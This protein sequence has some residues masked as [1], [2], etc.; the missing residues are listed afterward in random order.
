MRNAL[1]DKYSNSPEEKDRRE[2][3]HRVLIDHVTQW[4]NSRRL[5]PSIDVAVIEDNM[6]NI[7]LDAAGDAI[8]STLQKPVLK[9]VPYQPTDYDRHLEAT[10]RPESRAPPK[11]TTEFMR[12]KAWKPLLPHTDP[13]IGSASA[14]ASSTAQHTHPSGRYH[15]YNMHHALC[16]PW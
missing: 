13:N 12:D 11:S 5:H 8:R 6:G 14:E 16:N 2:A 1:R 9:R 4:R 7:T 3:A 15:P 10:A